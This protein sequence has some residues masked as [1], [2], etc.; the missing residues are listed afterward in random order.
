MRWRIFALFFALLFVPFLSA[1]IIISQQPLE[2]YNLGD[3]L[4]TSVTLT[5]NEGIYDFL[6]ISI[7]CNN[8]EERLPKEQINLQ[9]NNQI[10][11]EK[12]IFLIKKFI[13]SSLGVCQIKASLDDSPQQV[14]FSNDFEISNNLVIKSEIEDKQYGPGEKVLVKGTATKA[15]G[16]PV[17]G[18]INL[19]LS[20]GIQKGNLSE[21]RT[22]QGTINNGH[23][24]VELDLNKQ[25]EAGVY[26]LNMDGYERDPLD[27]ITN[28]GSDSQEIV[29]KQIPTS[30]GVVFETPEVSPGTNVRVKGILYDQSGE[31][32]ES[33]VILTIKDRN[34][35]ILEQIELGTDEFFEYPIAYNQVPEEW[36]AV[37]VSNKL[38]SEGKFNIIEKED[39]DVK[40]AN[41][42]LILKNLGNIFY[43]KT[44]L[45]KLGDETINLNPFLE[46]DETKKYSLSAPDGEYELSVISPDGE[47]KITGNFVLTGKSVSVKEISDFGIVFVYPLAWIFIF[48]VLGFM[49]YMV[50]RKGWK[51]TIL[52]K[53]NFRRHENSSKEDVVEIPSEKKGHHEEKYHHMSKDTNLIKDSRMKAEMS[54]S[55][56]GHKQKADL[57]NFKIRNFSEVKH[58]EK[59]VEDIIGKIVD[60]AEENHAH[61]YENQGNIFFIFAPI[62]T[63]TFKNE[64]RALKVSYKL[65]ELVKGHNK[66]SKQKIKFGISINSGDLMVS[67]ENKN[68]LKFMAFGHLLLD[69]KRLASISEGEEVYLS[70]SVKEAIMSGVKTKKVESGNVEAYL[71][72]EIKKD[73]PEE[74][75]KFLS[76]FVKR[77]DKDKK[78]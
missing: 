47:N 19:S 10:V 46:V 27:V 63:K 60:I 69:S 57:I 2:I 7:L 36:S 34:N 52:G 48:L 20:F 70:K 26:T 32:I 58:N 77:L 25:L 13:G 42:T 11:I 55:M 18:L 50:Y 66:L 39:V 73:N 31:K 76:E 8:H 30:L 9:A 72:E 37:A 23:F 15:N 64:R 3:I 14:V 62:V 21:K 56:K 53:L 29:V 44:L 59:I 71:V 40:I 35:K 61:I 75:K 22:Y 24:S 28:I 51:N 1:D 6:Q 49:G 17:E 38:T 67:L 16:K 68:I 54:L 43:N 78:N 74:H 4:E 65:L 41:E 33:M 5:T 45:I 12:S